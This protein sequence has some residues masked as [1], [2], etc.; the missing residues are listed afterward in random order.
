VILGTAGHIDHGKTTLVRALTGVDTDRLPEEK[1]RGITIELGFAP[2]EIDGVGTIGV[3]DVPGHEG[4]VRTML[5]GATGIDLGLLVIAADEGI[6]PQTREH[7]TILSLLGVSAGVVALTKSDLVDA[8]WIQ[9]VEEEVRAV[10]GGGALAGAEIV[11]CSATTGAGLDTLRAA[12]QRAALSVPARA[13][14]DLFRM[15]LDR[16]FSVKGTGTVVT[17]TIW[18]GTVTAEDAITI[19]PSSLP[20]RVRGIESHGRRATSATSG[21][22]AAIALGGVD[23]A[24]VDPRG[25]VLVSADVPWVATK[26]LRADVALLEGAPTLGPRTRVRFHLG[27]ADIGARVVAVGQPVVPGAAIPVRIALDAP[28]VARGGDRFVL[29]SAS[30]A[31]TIGGGI[32]SDPAPPPRRARPWPTAAASPAMLLEWMVQEGGGKGVELS[33]LAARLGVAPSKVATTV[34]RASGVTE[35]GARLFSKS[36]LTDA[37]AA[38]TDEIERAHRERPLEAGV[39]IQALR[40]RVRG[41]PAILDHVLA[42]MVKAEEVSV[43]AGTVARKGWTAGGGSGEEKRLAE[44]ASVLRSA[45]HA[46]PSVEELT[47][48]LGPDVPALLKLLGRRGEAIPVASDRWFSAEAVAALSTVIATALAGGASRTASELREATGL[49]RKYLI[50]FLEYCDRV[51]LTARRGDTRILRKAEPDPTG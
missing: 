45:G 26:V 15:P 10:L 11:R 32:V 28:V 38:V 4:F 18:S 13:A 34:K 36:V 33:S 40:S 22:R 51:G 29:R 48:D 23:R 25:S 19:M 3:V 50:P 21:A 37:R 8:D 2:L 7:L 39:P 1:K 17:G 35:I 9:L 5:A 24:D 43:D 14:T 44:I 49:T 6:M 46:P 41:V 42:R 47:R 31:A 27:T 20:V 16:A 30:P 12:I